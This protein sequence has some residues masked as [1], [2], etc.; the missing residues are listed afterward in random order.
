MVWGWRD[1]AC[2]RECAWV[3]GFWLGFG[4]VVMVGFCYELVGVA[5]VAKGWLLGAFVVVILSGN[6]GLCDLEVWCVVVCVGSVFWTL[7]LGCLGCVLIFL[8]G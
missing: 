6:L 5:L 7:V 8:Y 2:T 4:C 3:P 1:I